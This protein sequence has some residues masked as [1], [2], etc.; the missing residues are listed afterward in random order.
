MSTSE[1]NSNRKTG[2]EKMSDIPKEWNYQEGDELILTY[3]RYY[4]DRDEDDQRIYEEQTM[5][6]DCEYS[7]NHWISYFIGHSEVAHWEGYGFKI[8]YP[9]LGDET[10]FYL[11]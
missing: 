1:Y 11:C 4:G 10:G 3:Y 6:F 5:E 9:E 2:D 8:A 7:I